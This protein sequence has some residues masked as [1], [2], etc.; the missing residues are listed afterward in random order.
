ML[1]SYV[2]VGDLTQVFKTVASTEPPPKPIFNLYMPI[3]RFANVI[4]VVIS[5]I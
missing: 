1:A 3:L 2:G 5:V 4:T